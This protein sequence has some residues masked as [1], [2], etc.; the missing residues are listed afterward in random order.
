MQVSTGQPD[1]RSAIG[2]EGS[3]E[4]NDNAIPV[5]RV[6][7]LLDYNVEVDLLEVDLDAQ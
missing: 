5:E 6:G 3:S 7:K 4:A 2:I 1:V